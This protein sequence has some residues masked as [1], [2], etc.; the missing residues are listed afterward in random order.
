MLAKGIWYCFY[1]GTWVKGQHTNTVYWKSIFFIFGEQASISNW[2]KMVPKA[3]WTGWL[4]LSVAVITVLTLWWGKKRRLNQEMPYSN[5]QKH[6]NQLKC[7]LHWSMC[8]ESIC[9]EVLFVASHQHF[10]RRGTPF[11]GDNT[12]WQQQPLPDYTASHQN[13][14]KE[15]LWASKSDTTGQVPCPQPDGQRLEQHHSKDPNN[16]NVFNVMADFCIIM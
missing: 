16:I 3:R 2:C 13:K 6:Q 11:Q 12:P 15:P 5:Q 1:W 14:S 9:W 10:Y 8:C 4:N 7:K